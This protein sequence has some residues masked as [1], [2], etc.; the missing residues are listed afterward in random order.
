MA[1]HGFSEN[2]ARRVVRATRA[3]EAM[4]PD[5]RGDAPSRV[6]ESQEIIEGILDGD[7]AAATDSGETETTA[8]LS[9]WAGEGADWA[10]TG[11]NVTVTNRSTGLSASTGDYMQ[12]IEISGEWRPL[13][14]GASCAAQNEIHHITV[15]GSPTGGTFDLDVTVSG[16]TETLTF[17]Y[18]WLASE[19]EDEYETHSEIASGDVTVTDGPFPDGTVAVEF[20]GDLAETAIAL[21]VAD[22][23]SLTGG[24]GVAVIVSRAQTGSA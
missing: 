22:W 15:I 4:S 10:D 21:P 6:D 3:V 20:T 19:V 14:A 11:Q 5:M 2:G 8:T 17:D 13:A 18:D 16:T 7:L 1:V 23:S 12:A 24:S 9:V